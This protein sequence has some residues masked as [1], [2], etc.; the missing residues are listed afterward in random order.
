VRVFKYIAL[1]VFCGI[2]FS[3]NATHNRAG[4]ITMVHL[5][6]FTYKAIVTTY[7]KT[8]PP[9][10]AA[11]RP[12][13]TIKWGD[14]QE[15]VIPRV[16]GNGQM[17]AADVKMN[18]Y[19]GVH[20]YGGPGNFTVSMEDPNRNGNVINIPNSIE[21]VF[22]IETC[23][24]ISAFAGPNNSAQLLNPPIDEACAFKRFIHN[25]GAWDPDGD[26]LSYTL[27][28]CKGEN[29]ANIPGYFIPANVSINATTGDL[30]WD[31][32]TQAGEF[33]FAI[34]IEEW[35]KK[36]NTW[37]KVGCV[38]RDMQVNVIANCNNNPPVV[39]PLNDVCVLAG[40]THTQNITA[41]DADIGGSNV[42]TLTSTGAPYQVLNSPAQFTQGITGVSTVTGT[43]QWQTNCSHVS[44]FWYPV[45]VKATD[46]GVVSLVDMKTFKI[47]VV[48]PAPQNPSATPAGNNM[49]LS[50]DQSLCSQAIRYDIYR[51]NGYYGFNPSNCELGVPAYTGYSWIAS[52]NGVTN[53]SYLDDNGG[54]GLIH[55]NQYCYMVVVVFPDSA[56]SYASVEFCAEL[57]KDVPIITNVSVQTTNTS[58]GSNFV[59]WSKPKEL[60]TTIHK[61]P[62]KY[63][64]YHSPDMNGSNFTLIDSTATSFTMADTTYI[65]NNVNTKDHHNSYRIEI[66]NDSI[67]K[68]Y[69]IGSTHN[70]SSVFLSIAP[71][72]NALTLSWTYNVPWTNNTYVI[73]RYNNNTSSFD[74][75][76]TTSALSYKDEGLVN[77]ATYCY[78]IKAIGSYSTTGII[79]PI[80]NLSQ[81][82]CGVPVDLE[83]PCPPDLKVNPDCNLEQNT[84]TWT[85]PNNS[86]ADDV[87]M[88]RI[89]YKSRLDAPYTLLKSIYGDSDT[90]FTHAN[91]NS[92]AGCYY[93]T[94]IDSFFNESAPSVE[95]CVDNCPIYELPNVFSPDGDGINDYFI[96]FPYKFVHSIKLD[97]FNRWGQPVFTTTNPDINWN[98]MN[99]FTNQPCNDGVYFYTCTVYEIR[100]EGYVPRE[101]KGFVHLFKNSNIIPPA[102]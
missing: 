7:T 95:V 79:N 9:S 58:T 100:L 13:L 55:G 45:L 54:T 48:A 27:I 22:Y 47:K 90:T 74:S 68:R 78:Y 59:A 32:P 67:G 44:N 63:L 31:V 30:I 28:T 89:Y 50:W 40:T 88:Y 10:N 29:G 72:D 20:T 91:I 98:G 5:G 64:I 80:I 34:L 65:H 81:E 23:L 33:N 2:Y 70:A 61:G 84:L 49:F 8:S 35:R 15:E 18:K 21:T 75:I 46:N 53:T 16:N 96:P 41:T 19:E 43:F 93:V 12:E 83:A 24:V 36:G 57:K 37:V 52:V 73:Y 42:I 25:P 94:A 77:G 6:G 56:R 11:D 101:L 85:N 60:D 71:S 69:Y 3:A 51:K 66:Y 38:V 4:E 17:I 14:G 1:L 76:A 92:I 86:C 39:Q 97:I 99:Q 26:S 82:A 102:K 87:V 62:Y